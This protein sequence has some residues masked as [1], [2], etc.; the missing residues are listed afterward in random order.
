MSRTFLYARVS[1]EE[2]TP[3]NQVN[4]VAGSG[5]SVEPNRIVTECISGSVCA[6]ERPQFTKLVDRA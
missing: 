2:Q 4:E 6:F 3:L 1:T 5:F